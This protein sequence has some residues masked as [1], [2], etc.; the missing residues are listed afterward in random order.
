MALSV[1]AM[2]GITQA[3]NGHFDTLEQ[4]AIIQSFEVNQD[5]PRNASPTQRGSVK[6]VP[7]LGVIAEEATL[8][9]VITWLNTLRTE[10]QTAGI[11]DL[12]ER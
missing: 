2:Q 6:M 12:V 9:T 11:M 8:A 4:T 3:L 1:A 10:M 7:D 5:N